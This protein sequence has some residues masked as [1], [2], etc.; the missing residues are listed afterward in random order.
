MVDFQ[1]SN[2]FLSEQVRVQVLR[3]ANMERDLQEIQQSGMREQIESQ[4]G[5][6][7]TV[8]QALPRLED[9]Q[10]SFSQ[11]LLVLS[12]RIKLIWDN[13]QGQDTEKKA[14]QLAIDKI[15][16]KLAQEME[17]LQVTLHRQ[18][19]EI[20]SQ[21]SNGL[22]QR[23][24][25][26]EKEVATLQL[27]PVQTPESISQLSQ[28]QKNFQDLRR[29]VE[30]IQQPSHT[31]ETEVCTQQKAIENLQEQITLLNSRVNDLCKELEKQKKQ[32]TH[33]TLHLYPPSTW[34]DHRKLGRPN[35]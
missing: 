30:T 11:H 14:T 4:G 9:Q 8:Q 19:Q 7:M 22:Q 1:Q 17:T 35:H 27:Q 6:L 15:N 2:S 13:L 33:L 25:R 10:A 21:S 23:V 32:T 26:L 28:V 24:D 31:L 18:S 20:I 29:F 5:F 12:E 34:G 3:T 16:L